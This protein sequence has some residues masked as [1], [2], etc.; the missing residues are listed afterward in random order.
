[1]EPEENI[2][3]YLNPTAPEVIAGKLAVIIGAL[4]ST[5]IYLFFLSRRI[6]GEL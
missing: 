3:H 6:V 1:M 4:V 5:A 2:F